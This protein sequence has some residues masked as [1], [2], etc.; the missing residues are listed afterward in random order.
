[1]IKEE[2]LALTVQLTWGVKQSFRAYVEAVGGTVTVHA[3]ALSADTAFAFPRV[4]RAPSESPA[5]ELRFEGEVRFEAHGG[6]LSVALID[7]WIVFGP[8]GA[9]LTV[10]DT[11]YLPDRS[12]RLKIARLG[13]E[14]SGDGAGRVEVPAALTV[15]GSQLL[16]DVY[17]AQTA[18]DPISFGMTVESRQ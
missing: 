10:V 1:M 16:G 15:Q 9:V 11:D 14:T 8:D 3:P 6:M 12:K 2:D 7:P 5:G 17:P 13:G 18:L 4:D